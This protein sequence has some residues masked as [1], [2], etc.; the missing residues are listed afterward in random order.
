MSCRAQLNMM[1]S[2]DWMRS[3]FEISCLTVNSAEADM[4][5]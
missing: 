1:N 4:I 5:L 2:I 3:E